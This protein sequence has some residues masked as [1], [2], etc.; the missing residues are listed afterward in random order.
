MQMITNGLQVNTDEAYNT[1]E[2][3]NYWV[4]LINPVLTGLLVY[5]GEYS[6]W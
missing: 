5:K 3:N 2:V 1:N 6:D 4:L